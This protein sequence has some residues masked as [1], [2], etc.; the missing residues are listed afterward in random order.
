MDK[1]KVTILLQSGDLDKALSAFIIANGY[2]VA[3]H[4]SNDV[5]H[6]L[7]LQLPQETAGPVLVSAASPTRRGKVPTGCWRPT[8]FCSPWSRC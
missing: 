4:R 2:A 3:R 7:G 8:I 1:K 6:D 5:V